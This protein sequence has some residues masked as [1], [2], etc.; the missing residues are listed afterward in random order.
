MNQDTT[1]LIVDDEEDIRELLTLDLDMAGF[2]CK[3]A[4]NGE[5][6]FEIVAAENINVIISD[7]NMPGGNGLDLLKKVK[8]E[9]PEVFVILMVSDP[10][11]ESTARELGAD[12]IITKPFSFE[13]IEEKIKTLVSAA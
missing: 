12:H 2:N 5:H 11:Q 6:A 10:T 1:V 9:K 8:T 4:P 3:E 13:D 7:V